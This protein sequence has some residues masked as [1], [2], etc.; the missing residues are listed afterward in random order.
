MSR[1]SLASRDSNLGLPETC[2]S[3]EI[4]GPWAHFRRVEGNIV[5]QTYRIPPRT[6]VA[7]IVAAML[8]LERDGYYDAFGPGSSRVA[9]EPV[10][11]LR[12]MNVP[13]NTLSTANEHLKTVP[14]RGHTR[15]SM[16]DPTELRQQ[17]NY[18]LI[19]DPAYRIDLQ[20]ADDDL[21]ERFRDRL[22]SGT[23]Y[24]PPSLGLSEHLA[25]VEFL[26]SFDVQEHDPETVRVD[27][28]VVN[29]TDSIEV[30]PEKRVRV[31]RAPG[32]MAADEGGRTTTDFLSVGYSPAGESLLVA[33]AATAHVDGRRVMFS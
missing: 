13:Q 10:G 6:T 12:T 31:E 8:G 1:Q 24:Y 16:P 28:A 17:H 21:F 19:V 33:D 5:K 11:E 29:A 27:S 14:S 25:E 15:I 4:R 3:F 20:L 9:I 22:E 30:E 26:G 2:L 7:G 32:Y 23:S 18:E